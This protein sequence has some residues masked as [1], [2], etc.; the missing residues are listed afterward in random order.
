MYDSKY[1]RTILVTRRSEQNQQQKKLKPGYQ[2][3]H[4]CVQVPGTGVE[5]K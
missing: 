2:Q 5:D 3:L 1:Y 4:T